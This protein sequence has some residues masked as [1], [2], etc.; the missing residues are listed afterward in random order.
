VA[1]ES[2][3]AFC[4]ALLHPLERTSALIRDSDAGPGWSALLDPSRAPA[5]ALPYLAQF[6]GVRVTRGA[7]SGQQ[8]EE[9]VNAAGFRRGRPASIVAAVAAT[10][11]GDRTVILTERV[12]GEAYQLLVQTY[13]DQTPDAAAAEAAA[14][15]QKPAGIVLTFEVVDGQTYAQLAGRFETYADL[16][17]EYADYAEM[18]SDT[19]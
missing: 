4:R 15:A 6:V 9:I 1:D 13:T 17:A 2:L 18:A 10:L 7:A 14:R 5:S 19:P 8:R 12:D 3:L 16:A 11:T